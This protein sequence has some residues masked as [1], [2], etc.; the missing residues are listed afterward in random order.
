MRVIRPVL[1]ILLSSLPLLSGCDAD[2]AK[3]VLNSHSNAGLAGTSQP[4]FA[5]AP[6]APTTPAAASPGIHALAG[7]GS[8][9]PVPAA[10]GQ[11]FA[12]PS[13]EVTESAAS[14]RSHAV[15]KMAPD[16]ELKDQNYQTVTLASLKGS[17]VVLYFYPMA[18]TPGCTCQATEFTKLLW[19][20]SQSGAKVVG[21]SPGTVLDGKYF[22]DKYDLK[23]PV[24]AD[25]EKDAI[26]KYGAWV[27]IKEGP[28]APG[29]FI[30][31]TYLISPDGRI[32]W[33]WPEVIPQG[34]A[35]RVLDRLAKL[36]GA[37]TK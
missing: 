25:P 32:A 1:G 35:Q 19:V 15:G 23:F 2:P 8:Q 28:A 34:H 27:D 7:S 36:Q 26:R 21:V 20:F 30:R 37:A 24:L 33:H 17:W 18:D 16:F 6:A 12:T 14:S 5:P 3:P 31:S 10:Q 11:E 22:S 29:Q 4:G 9:A 13:P